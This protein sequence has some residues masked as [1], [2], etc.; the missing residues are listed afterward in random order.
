MLDILRGDTIRGV[1]FSNY[2][3]FGYQNLYSFPPPIENLDINLP[4][5]KSI[6]KKWQQEKDQFFT[7]SLP[8]PTPPPTK[9]FGGL[10]DINLF[11]ERD[12]LQ[13]AVKSI[14]LLIGE[15]VLEKDPSLLNLKFYGILPFP[16]LKV[17]SYTFFRFYAVKKRNVPH[18]CTFSLLI[19]KIKTNF[20]YDNHDL[21][22]KLIQETVN[23]LVVYLEQGEW[24]SNHISPTIVEK[25]QNTILNFFNTL[26][27]ISSSHVHP[28]LDSH[29]SKKIIVTGLKNSGKNSFLLTL[30]RKFDQMD[31]KGTFQNGDIHMV[32]I[33]GTTV[34][35][36]DIEPNII[37]FFNLTAHFEIYL[38]D[39]DLLFF[40][41]DAADLSS[42]D[43]SKRLFLSI[44]NHLMKMRVSIPLIVILSKIDKDIQYTPILQQNI[45]IIKNEFSNSSLNYSNTILFFETSIFSI[46]SCLTA[47]SEGLLPLLGI[48]KDLHILLKNFST[49]LEL[50]GIALLNEYGLVFAEYVEESKKR[51][52]PS[53]SILG[54]QL[55]SLMNK[56]QNLGINSENSTISTQLGD[57]HHIL[58][59]KIKFSMKF[60]ILLFRSQSF[61]HEVQDEL[62]ILSQQLAQQLG[63]NS[64]IGFD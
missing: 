40:F 32:K 48:Q 45:S 16:D 9:R 3:E 33:L 5:D 11:T 15:K 39:A 38:D 30:H 59:K 58:L 37:P 51:A 1:V 14:S 18:A 53:L 2:D 50:D 35:N 12:F 36:W 7:Q 43:E 10:R 42:F 46:S 34:L 44:L 55:I 60:Y 17:Y 4:I 26:L 21:I 22:N 6:F 61:S 23:S 8:E 62:H 63:N 25:I 54:Y 49:R 28:S 27:P 41:V 47:F 29:R 19:D 56:S 20:I 57:H 64:N 52:I 31:N 13:I 24:S